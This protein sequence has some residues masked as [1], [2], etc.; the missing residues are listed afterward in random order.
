MLARRAGE[1]LLEEF[2]RPGGPRHKGA[3]HADVDDEVED[4]LR[5]ELERAFPDDGFKGEEST[6]RGLNRLSRSGRTWVVDPNDGTS[7][8]IR[9][10]R[11]SA[12]S[13][14]LITGGRPVLGVVFSPTSPDDRGDLLVWAEGEPFCR[15]GVQVSRAPLPATLGPYA[16]VLASNSAERHAT[17][18]ARAIAPARFRAMPSIAYRLALVAAGDADATFSLNSVSDWDVAGGHALLRSVGGVMLAGSGPEFRYDPRDSFSAEVFAGHPEAAAW[19][20][21]RNWPEMLQE[22]H[23]AAP[24]ADAIVRRLPPHVPGRGDLLREAG[25]VARAQGAL[26]GQVIG[27]ALGQMVEFE[28]EDAIAYKHP[29]GVR[30]ML[31]GGTHHTIAGQPTD[32]SE[33]ALALARS[34][35]REG[36][37]DPVA[38]LDAYRLWLDS[39]PF[40]VGHTTRSG[41]AGAPLLDSKANGSLM[42]VS[43]LAIHGWSRD[44]D[45]LASDARADSALTHPNR[46]CCDAV[47]AYCVAIAHAIRTGDG[48]AAVYEAT[49]AWVGAQES[50]SAE[51]ATIFAG[52]DVAAPE[53]CDQGTQGFVLIALRNAFHQLLHVPSFEEGLV[54][55]VAR[56]GDTD[57][58]GAIAG[59]LLGA[60]HGRD[61]VPRRWQRTVLSCRPLPHTARPRPATFWPVDVL[62]VAE[63]LAAAG[64]AAG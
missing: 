33:M 26:L 29:D 9:G 25:V 44:R 56:G 52:P 20:A 47:A 35:L 36:R 37:F 34:I 30:D 22:V 54:A 31:D 46:T 24:V 41:I 40:D 55:T 53:H 39:E 60:V 21:R 64:A 16:V 57:T 8:F 32:D 43:P 19:L 59:A 61:A 50:F 18:N 51:V 6:P 2:H 45:A 42:R 38:A 15:N 11:G 49:S 62:Q 12:V 27:D 5:E 48:P 14:A 4:L 58:N 3:R 7:A 23:G 1:R 63:A 17:A 13:I 28:P 10:R